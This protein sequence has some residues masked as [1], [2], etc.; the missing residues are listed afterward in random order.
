MLPQA[1]V[2]GIEQYEIRE[3]CQSCRERTLHTLSKT[4]S[5]LL[6]KLPATLPP[7]RLVT[8]APSLIIYRADTSLRQHTSAQSKVDFL[9]LK[10]LVDASAP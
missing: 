1:V 5:N 6:D 7:D 10:V 3:V 9:Q 2:V 4:E 8:S